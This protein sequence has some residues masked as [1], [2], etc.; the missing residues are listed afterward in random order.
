MP[1]NLRRDGWQRGIPQVQAGDVLTQLLCLRDGFRLSALTSIPPLA[2]NM[3]LAGSLSASA[4]E[5]GAL[6]ALVEQSWDAWTRTGLSESPSQSVEWRQLQL[7]K[8]RLDSEHVVGRWMA[9]QF[10]TLLHRVMDQQFTNPKAVPEFLAES[11]VA[12]AVEHGLR[13]VLVL[14]VSRDYWQWRPE[15]HLLVVAEVT[16]NNTPTY[17]SVLRAIVAL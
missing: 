15:S 5:R 12:R 13:H 17:Q 6:A 16:R 10:D 4:K 8:V 2:N 1:R 9:E 7:F 3:W 14:P 11:T